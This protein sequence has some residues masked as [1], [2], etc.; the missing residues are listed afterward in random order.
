MG[1]WPYLAYS[2]IRRAGGLQAEATYDYC[3]GSGKWCASRSSGRSPRQLPL[4]CPR[5][6]RHTLWPAG[7]ILLEGKLLSPRS[8]SLHMLADRSER[9]L[10]CAF[11]G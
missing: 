3:S 4:P 1:G 8:L 6:E 2:Y 7:G 5:M 10:Q 9:E 11:E